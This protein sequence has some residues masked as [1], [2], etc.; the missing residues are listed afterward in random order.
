MEANRSTTVATVAHAGVVRLSESRK[1][2]LLPLVAATYFMVS[3]G[4]YGLEDAVGQAGYGR[5]LLLLLAIPLL[6]GLPTALM[7]GELAAAIPEEGGFYVWVRRALGPFWGFQEAWLSLAASLFAMAVYPKLTV[8]YLTQFAPSLTAGHRG[9]YWSLAIILVCAAW[10]LRGAYSV[11]QSSLWMFA[12]LLVPFA[13]IVFFGVLHTRLLP[14]FLSRALP[15]FRPLGPLYFS[16]PKGGSMAAALLVVMWNLMGWDNA[17]TCA[18]EVHD[19][20]RNYIR[21]MLA[22]VAVVSM[23]YLLPVAM[24]A[25]TGMPADKFATGAWV[26]AADALAGGHWLGWAVVACGAV[27]GVAM[28]NASTL[29]YARIPAAM[30]RDGLAPGV[31]A[32]HMKNGV[33]WVSVC[34]CCAAWALCVG[35]SFDRLVELNVLIY[36]VSLILEFAALLVLRVRE[37]AMPRPFLIPGGLWFAGL[38]AMGPTALVLFAL[39]SERNENLGPV[40]TPVFLAAVVLAGPSAFYAI[41][42]LKRLRGPA[43]RAA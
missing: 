10:N 37:P 29:S 20:Q 26:A 27:T 2:W 1:L 31:L 28:F 11:G 15:N 23:S 42:A 33:P 22:A 8:I 41:S 32:Q 17:S 19:P 39:Y 43:D 12:V 9:I 7:V 24:V 21:A 34:A 6:W 16:A 18:R 13:G 36:G 35:F 5:C 14:H 4:P 30:A 40:R 25:F 38:L 3:G